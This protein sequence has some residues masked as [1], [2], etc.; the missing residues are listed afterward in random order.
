MDLTG[1][2]RYRWDILA[3]LIAPTLA[4]AS[5]LRFV[6]ADW[7]PLA[8][9]L[10]LVILSAMVCAVLLEALALRETFSAGSDNGR[11]SGFATGSVIALPLADSFI[12]KWFG[13]PANW[14]WIT[15]YIGAGLAVLG[16]ALRFQAKRH[17][18][19]CFSHTIRLLPDHRLVVTGPYRFVRHPAYTGTFLIV[20][21]LSIAMNSWSGIMLTLA[22]SPFAIMRMGYE[23]EEL[24]GR[25][26]PAYL[27]Y[28]ARV[29]RVFP[30]VFQTAGSSESKEN[31]GDICP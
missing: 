11:L 31:G 21:G 12:L 29:G 22:L 19:D 14:W 27:D 28:R 10:K 6:G 18:G 25:F 20:S 3:I 17:L 8:L 9:Q 7:P 5:Q 26:G 30:I 24:V 2:P 4:V 13:M 1:S 15:G 16:S 23:E